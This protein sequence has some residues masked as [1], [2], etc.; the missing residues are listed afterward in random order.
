MTS[1]VSAVKL[2]G[3]AL[4]DTF[5]V[6]EMECRPF[7]IFWKTVCALKFVT[8]DH[9]GSFTAVFEFADYA[10]SNDSDSEFQISIENLTIDGRRPHHPE[11]LELTRRFT[12]RLTMEK[13]MAFKSIVES[14]SS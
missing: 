1:K 5:F 10:T 8:A 4:H 2:K 6:T 14:R 7:V 11:H 13:E 12:S 3:Q 9:S